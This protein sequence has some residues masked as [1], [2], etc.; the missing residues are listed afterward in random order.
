VTSRSIVVSVPASSRTGT[1]ATVPLPTRNSISPARGNARVVADG[2]GRDDRLAGGAR[3]RS[4]ETPD[5]RPRGLG[6]GD[7]QALAADPD[8]VL[9]VDPEAVLEALDRLGAGVERPDRFATGSPSTE[10]DRS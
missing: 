4:V 8:L 5:E 9:P 10:S 2:R 1:V 3:S 7:S 6:D